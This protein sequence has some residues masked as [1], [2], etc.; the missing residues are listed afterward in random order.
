MR[1]RHWKELQA[2]V[3]EEFTHTDPEFTLDKLYAMKLLDHQDKIE[4][5]C[6]HARQQ[7]KIEKSLDNIE[8]LWDRSI[9][10]NL[11]IDI[12]HTKGSQETC[13]QIKQT[14][15]IIALIEDHSGELAKH[16]ASQFYKQF[17]DRID[18]WENNIAKI[19]ETLEILMS[20]Q[21]KWQYLESIFGGQQHIQK[22]LAQEF[23]IFKSVDKEFKSEMLRIYRVKNAYKSLVQDNPDFINQLNNLNKS[24]EA[25]QK[26]LNDWLAARRTL[27]PRF[28]FLSNEDLLEIIGQAKNPATINKHIKKIFE[29][30]NRI[31]V[32]HT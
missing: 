1:D 19:T 3:K 28:F 7:L 10:T 15:N 11:E 13:Y 4:E 24:L 31:D 18:Y 21:E 23:S 29:G 30:I 2:E 22:Q 26:K 12:C 25:V 32:D 20:V 6:S 9:Q 5:I 27:F 17:D 14:D 8:E 16:K